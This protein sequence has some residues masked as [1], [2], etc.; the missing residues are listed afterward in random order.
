MINKLGYRRFCKYNYNC[1]E[2]PWDEFFNEKMEKIFTEKSQVIDIGGGLR[3][4]ETKNNRKDESNNWLKEYIKKVDYKIL[5]KVPDY[6][7]DIVGDI[8]SLPF[9]DE[10]IDAIVCIAVLE[11][12][13]EPLKAVKEMYRVL[14]KG[15]YCFIYV[16]FLFYYH[17][18]KGYYKDFYRFTY[19][20]VEYMTKDF[21]S[22][23]IQ[24]VRGSLATVMNLL[25]FF[26]KNTAMFDF[27]D[28][29]LGKIKTKQTSGYNIFCVK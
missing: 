7:P 9:A 26:S 6:H 22:V 29:K 14:K 1:M 10:S 3:T 2:N 11:H 12:V 20:G 16:P 23:E 25:P 8:H 4:D 24:N 28:K 15:G 18:L 5:D 13:E 27:L 21:S 17:P 19:D